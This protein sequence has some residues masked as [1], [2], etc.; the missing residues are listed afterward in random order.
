MREK[1]GSENHYEKADYGKRKRSGGKFEKQMREIARG[2][3]DHLKKAK[4]KQKNKRRV[5][6][7]KE[8][9]R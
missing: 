3:T 8:E 7:V 2:G 9:K 4:Q 6:L 1:A 5:I